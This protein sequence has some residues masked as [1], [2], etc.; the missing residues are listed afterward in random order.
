VKSLAT[1]AVAFKGMHT[2]Y[3]TS[4]KQ[5]NEGNHMPLYSV[6]NLNNIQHTT[7]A[8]SASV[9]PDAC[10]AVPY[11][12]QSKH[13]LE[14]PVSFLNNLQQPVLHLMLAQLCHISHK[15]NTCY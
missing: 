10:S 12:A 13:M 8:L 15:A 4:I 3:A 11:L 9:A 7:A 5:D 1:V 6:S 14:N 2:I